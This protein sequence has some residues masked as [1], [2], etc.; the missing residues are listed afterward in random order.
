MAND[1]ELGG[2]LRRAA[3]MVKVPDDPFERLQRRRRVK[4]R[5][6]RLMAGAVSMVLVGGLV[7]GTLTV[8]AHAR[9]GSGTI[10][11]GSNG[12]GLRGGVMQGLGLE[13]GDYVYRTVTLTSQ[14][15][16]TAGSTQL[17]QLSFTLE[18]WWASDG[19]GRVEYTCITPDCDTQYGFGPAGVFGP[20]GFPTD[21]DM[22][23][24]SG[25]PAELLPQLEARS[26][27]GGQ[28]PEPAFSPGPE[29]T[30]GVTVGSVLD[31]V[32]NILEEP[33]GSLELKA[34]CF[35]V[36]SDMPS[37]ERTDDATDP[38]G[39]PAIR[40]RFSMDTWGSADYYFD[41]STHLL[42]AET[43]G[44]AGTPEEHSSWIY[45]MGIVGSTDDKPGDGHWLFPRS[46]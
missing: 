12:Q 44:G 18:T 32:V 9:H 23:G 14:G 25:D 11:P 30:P 4:Q 2:R 20:G 21:D 19:S 46:G 7:A 17:D 22:T 45:D 43:G 29:L 33:N 8:L 39:R 41:P 10:L 27:D 6:E 24:L 13:P 3:Q 28:S 37:V 36:A 38:A 35:A 31:A 5:N 26:V 16:F 15:Y 1:S 40:L 42:M 34:A